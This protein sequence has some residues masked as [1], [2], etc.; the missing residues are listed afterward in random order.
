MIR[1]P[2]H[3][4]RPQARPTVVCQGT[5]GLKNLSIE[6]SLD[7]PLPGFDS[8]Q[9]A[10]DDL[11]AGKFIVVLDDEDRENEGDLII[12]ADK[13]STSARAGSARHKKPRTMGCAQFL[14]RRRNMSPS[15]QRAVSYTCH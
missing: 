5:P 4:S 7:E 15:W 12:A 11:A 10:L 9:A 6:Q 2:A 1:R 14:S 8:I 3:P 13:V